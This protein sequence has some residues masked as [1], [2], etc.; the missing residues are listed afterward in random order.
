MWY[1]D[2]STPRSDVLD[3]YFSKAVLVLIAITH[4]SPHDFN[5]VHWKVIRIGVSQYIIY[6]L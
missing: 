5:T 6:K 1:G 3:N 4:S 2:I